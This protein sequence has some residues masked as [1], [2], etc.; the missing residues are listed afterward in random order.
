MKK[1][2]FTFLLLLF[3]ITALHAQK[4]IAV[5]TFAKGDAFYKIGNREYRIRKNQT[6]KEKGIIITK[7]GK[8]DLQIASGNIIRLSENSSLYLKELSERGEE[9]K[10]EIV[11]N[12]GKLY[13]NIT[14]KLKGKSFFK[15]STPTAVASV[16]GTQ[17]LVSEEN[18]KNKN[19]NK[20]NG[21]IE[22]PTGFYVN[23]GEV[24]LKVDAAKCNLEVL[25]LCLDFFRD[26]KKV[27]PRI[28]KEGQQVTVSKKKVVQRRLE[29]KVK[30][31]MENEIKDMKLLDS[32][33]FNCY[34]RMMYRRYTCI[35]RYCW[36]GY[37]YVKCC[38]KYYY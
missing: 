1:I 11:L 18:K 27:K 10:I 38:Y 12:I 19:E 34:K 2:L 30:K 35:C 3:T 25:G 22:I 7:K 26:E 14:K 37:T 13:A 20:Q 5:A 15:I 17:L 31:N 36:N 8:V 33:Q 32:T 4:T 29:R 21:D 9:Q 16:R 6:F 24:E 23:E 28:V